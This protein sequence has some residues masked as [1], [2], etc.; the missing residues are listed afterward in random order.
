MITPPVIQS[1]ELVESTTLSNTKYLKSNVYMART[2]R[3][4]EIIYTGDA[5]KV[6]KGWG[7]L[8]TVP[9]KYRPKHDRY[10]YVRTTNDSS[11]WVR[12][13]DNGSL[14]YYS[15]VAYDYT[16]NFQF[17]MTYISAI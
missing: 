7:T 3:I 16:V 14:E 8:G 5:L 15:S 11:V 6:D 4:V 12:I 9:E 1:L 17:A 13:R 2:G 10:S